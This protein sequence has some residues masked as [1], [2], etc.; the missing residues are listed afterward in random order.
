MAVVIEKNNK[1][2]AADDLKVAALNSV[3]QS[4]NEA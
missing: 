3:R 2:I 1:V 4:R